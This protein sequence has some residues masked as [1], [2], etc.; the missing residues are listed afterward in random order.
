MTT[1]LKCDSDYFMIVVVPYN[2][3][4]LIIFGI[5]IPLIIGL[6]LIK[7]QKKQSKLSNTQF[8]IARKDKYLEKFET[9]QKYGILYAGLNENTYLWE[10]VNIYLKVLISLISNYYSG[11][12][13][14]DNMIRMSFIVFSI[15]IYGALSYN[16]KPYFNP[17][18]NN[19]LH[20]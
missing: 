5:I 14:G 6:S 10:F 4:I 11:Y 7:G 17:N 8:I 20:L 9:M 18:L 3:F 12:A 15:L 19:L 2:L 1:A 16:K 13:Y